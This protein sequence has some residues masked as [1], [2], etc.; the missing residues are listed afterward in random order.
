MRAR[1]WKLLWRFRPVD[2]D[3][4]RD[5]GNPNRY[6]FNAG[7]PDFVREVLQNILDAASGSSIEALFKIIVLR[8]R[9]KDEFLEAIERPEIEERIE[10]A[11]GA[12]GQVATALAEG[13]A[14]LRQND[15]LVLLAVSDF[16]GWG[17]TGK[18][19]GEGRYAALVRNNLDSDKGDSAAVYGLGKAVWTAFSRIATV[20]FH[21][22]VSSD[23]DG[24]EYRFIGKSEP[25][26]HEYHGDEYGTGPGWFGAP[27]ADQ[28]WRARQVRMG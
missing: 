6:V 13:L 4:G 28:A 21:S 2:A 11:V 22:K 20:L 24:R 14:H 27:G 19:D 15:E 10:L 12:G 1:L 25:V 17:L 5:R 18:E 16:G 7:I 26:W 3:G 23:P 8:G 9:E